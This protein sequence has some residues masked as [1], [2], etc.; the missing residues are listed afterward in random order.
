MN[1]SCGFVAVSGN[2]PLTGPVLH[3]PVIALVSLERKPGAGQRLDRSAS[4]GTPG[5]RLA[6]GEGLAEPRGSLRASP[7]GLHVAG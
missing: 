4:R 6:C 5:G 3:T 1:S 2:G 7:Q